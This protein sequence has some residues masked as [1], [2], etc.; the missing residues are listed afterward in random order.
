MNI[1]ELIVETLK[2]NRKLIIG[3][4]ALF[5]ISFIASWILNAPKAETIVA[6]TT[7]AV[8]G[9]GVSALELFIKNEMS[10]IQTYFLSIFFGIIAFVSVIFNGFSIG[11]LGP[12]FAK[13]F[14]NGGIMYILYLIPHGIF[15]FSGMIL[16]SAGGILLFLFIWRFIK[17]LRSSDTNGASEAFEKTKK[18]LIQSVILLVIAMILTLIAAPI[19]AYF[20]VGFSQTIMGLLGLM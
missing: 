19:E 5:I 12:L 9:N 11:G 18:T 14:P 15:E 10:G 16:E 7:S 4:Y 3:L 20:S 1:K 2:D 13:M 17:A 6:N 8:P